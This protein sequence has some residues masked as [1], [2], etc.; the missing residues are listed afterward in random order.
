MVTVTKFDGSRQTYSREKV[1][2]TSM[3]MGASR[4]EAESIADEVE[5]SL[6]DGM[7]TQEILG[8][9]RRCLREFKPS[10]DLRVDL[11]GA[12]S[13]LRSKPDFECFVRLMLQEYG[14][15][16]TPNQIV[17]GLCV[18]HEIDAIA[19]KGGDVV[20]VEVKHHS[21]PHTYTGLDIMK[22]ARATF[23]DLTEGNQHGDNDIGFSKALVVCNTKFSDHAKRYSDCRRIDHIG[24]KSPM[25]G[26]LELRIEEK[27]LYPITL[28]RDLDRE[29]RERLGNRGVVLLKQV[30][31]RSMKSLARISGVPRDRLEEL[32][33]F[34]REI[35][36]E[37]QGHGLSL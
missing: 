33:D 12:I 34:A 36:N 22:E 17:R 13:L 10:L 26:G 16:V 20:Y 9:V 23:E 28:F 7:P 32:A 2:L 4:E 6:Y 29:D 31:R 19:R 5:R 8:I 27:G 35:L 37:K 11:R 3:R 21:N 30:L 14:Y 18:E 25:G 15:K 24:W 1:L